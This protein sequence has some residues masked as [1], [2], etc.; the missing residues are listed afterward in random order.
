MTNYLRSCDLL[1]AYGAFFSFALN[2]KIFNSSIEEREKKK[3]KIT[4]YKYIPQPVA[5]F[6]GQRGLINVAAEGQ[7]KSPQVQLELWSFVSAFPKLNYTD[8]PK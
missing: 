1:F 3:V 6:R 4:L 5:A 8:V 7:I 2:L